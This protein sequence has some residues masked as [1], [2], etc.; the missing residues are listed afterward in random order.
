MK[1]CIFRTVSTVALFFVFSAGVA[2]ADPKGLWLAQDGVKVRVGTCGQA[3]CARVAA[4]KSPLD[5]DTGGPWTDKNNPDPSKRGLPLVGVAV[6][7][8]M[9]PDGPGRWSGWLYN[10][11]DGKTH[12]GHLLELGPATIRVEGCALGIC[13]GRNLTRL[14]CKGSQC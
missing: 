9:M 7:Y 8:S 13:G 12:P 2:L 10:S 1:F 11:E 14:H 6:L 5:P 3:L 4:P